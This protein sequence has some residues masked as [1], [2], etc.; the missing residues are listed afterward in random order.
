MFLFCALICVLF[1]VLMSKTELVFFLMS[2]DYYCFA[3]LPHG[4]VGLSAVCDCGPGHIWE[5]NK[6]QEIT[7]YTAA[8]RSA[9]SKPS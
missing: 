1:V 6:T 3:A 7:T 8:K 5:S 2:Y 9:I 4:A